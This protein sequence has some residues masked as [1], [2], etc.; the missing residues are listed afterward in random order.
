MIQRKSLNYVRVLNYE[1]KKTNELIS[2]LIPFYLLNDIINEK[3]SV[4]QFDDMTILQVEILNF[5]EYNKDVI[6]LLS[7][8]FSRFDQLT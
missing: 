4:D 1:S 6:K 3:K 5:V 8:L 7:R 2:N